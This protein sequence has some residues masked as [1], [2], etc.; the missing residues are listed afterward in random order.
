M[1]PTPP[2]IEQGMKRG[3]V[4]MSDYNRGFE[5]L[6]VAEKEIGALRK[7][8]DA[9]REALQKIEAF[10]QDEGNDDAG[11]MATEM[12]NI[13]TEALADLTREQSGKGEVNAGTKRS[14]RADL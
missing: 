14:D 5:L 6:E 11:M 1:T 8:R 3:A 7:E 10:G 9:L 12:Y 13:A 2:K 4:G